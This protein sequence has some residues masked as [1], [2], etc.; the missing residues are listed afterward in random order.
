MH[1]LFYT[2][3]LWRKK[4]C[5]TKISENN[6]LLSNSILV[7][8]KF[9][10]LLQKINLSFGLKFLLFI[11]KKKILVIFVIYLAHHL[12]NSQVHHL[13]SSQ[14]YHFSNTNSPAHH[15]TSSPAH[16]LTSSLSYHFTS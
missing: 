7:C 13:T 11:F 14:T 9:M 5:E 1:L 6:S 12:T 4:H 3:L 2:T 16:H 15:L 8:P 10:V